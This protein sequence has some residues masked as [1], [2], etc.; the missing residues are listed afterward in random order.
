MAIQLTN[1][2]RGQK[3]IVSSCILW[4]LGTVLERPNC[5]EVA[6]AYA[7]VVQD[8]TGSVAQR[9]AADALCSVEEQTA[10]AKSGH[11]RRC[12]GLTFRLPPGRMAQPLAPRPLPMKANERA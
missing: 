10:R 6:S 3:R 4:H 11:A 9:Q 12:E 5:A 7:S 8:I 1:Y 2:H